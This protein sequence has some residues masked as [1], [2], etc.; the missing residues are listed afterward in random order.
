MT[1]DELLF[2]DAMPGA[3]PLYDAL[4]AHL[5]AFPGVTVK[6]AKTQITFLHRYGFAFVSLRR[7]R[8]CPAVFLILTLGLPQRLDSPRIAVATEPYPGRWTHHIILSDL[9]QL[10]G[11]LLDWCRAAYEFARARERR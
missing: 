5:T 8:G 2:F 10:D 6:V 4:R 3:L 1:Q 9:A 11:E 7:M